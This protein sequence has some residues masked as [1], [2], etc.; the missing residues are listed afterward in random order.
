MVILI[1]IWVCN[2]LIRIFLT[3]LGRYFSVLCKNFS[4]Y[5]RYSIIVGWKIDALHRCSNLTINYISLYQ[6]IYN[7]LIPKKQSYSAYSIK[8]FEMM[9]RIFNSLQNIFSIFHRYAE[10]RLY[11]YNVAVNSSFAEKDSSLPCQ[12]HHFVSLLLSILL[13]FFVFHDLQ[14]DH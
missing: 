12:F 10:R 4:P 5:W 1:R 8:S 14:S 7:L 13:C 6:I 3:G 2:T 11:P 9:E